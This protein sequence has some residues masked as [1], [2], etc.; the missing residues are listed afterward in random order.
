[1]KLRYGVG[2]AVLVAGSAWLAVS[3]IHKQA[4]TTAGDR[5]LDHGG[6]VSTDRSLPP[7]LNLRDSYSALAGRA[8]TGNKAAALRLF[9]EQATC[10]GVAT[11]K[12]R[13][14]EDSYETWLSVHQ[15]W[16]ATRS[17]ADQVGIK[18]RTQAKYQALDKN[19]ELCTNVDAS[20]NDGRIYDAAL[21]AAKNGDTMAT[22]CLIQ[23]PWPTRPMSDD[24]A[25]AFDRQRLDLAERDIERG[26][27]SAVW[28]M[29]D[30]YSSTGSAN[31]IPGH[32]HQ[33]R[34][35]ELRMGYL[36]QLGRR[37]AGVLDTA[38]DQSVELA[39]MDVSTENAQRA[40][41][42]AKQVYANSFA[43]SGP[44]PLTSDNACLGPA[45]SH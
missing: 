33:S 21:Q 30:L 12:S 23:A 45:N 35:D 39:E 8:A 14:H 9:N 42:W 34:Y 24:D 5:P 19:K 16:L 26:S 1:M 7:V 11:L 32:S 27:W 41:T 2:L 17:P 22:A 40:S 20:F 37:Q 18:Q 15:A 4:Q 38:A 31:Q 43:Y 13:L 29:H 44:P 6:A 10:Q 36:Q 28:A 3:H 25:S